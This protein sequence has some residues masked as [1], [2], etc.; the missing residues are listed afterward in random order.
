MSCSSVLT[1]VSLLADSER[2]EGRIERRR[3]GLSAQLLQRV[4]QRFAQGPPPI[5]HALE[6]PYPS[7]HGSA[8]P[9]AS[10]LTARRPAPAPPRPQRQRV[11]GTHVGDRARR[12]LDG[13]H[14]CLQRRAGRVDQHVARERIGEHFGPGVGLATFRRKNAETSLA[15]VVAAQSR[16]PPASVEGAAPI[17][18][19]G[20]EEDGDAV[21]GMLAKS[22]CERC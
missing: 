13:D 2:P 11:R 12:E 3:N 19:P 7:W 9:R 17:H 5:E 22:S 20:V 16:E 4:Q 21:S 8:N 6:L 18:L 14:R 15:W 1:E 10:R